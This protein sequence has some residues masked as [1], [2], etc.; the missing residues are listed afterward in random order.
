MKTQCSAGVRAGRWV[1]MEEKVICYFQEGV[2][3]SCFA[4]QVVDDAKMMDIVQRVRKPNFLF[5]LLF[6]KKPELRSQDSRKY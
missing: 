2:F 3:D 5:Q 1:R 6:W 4:E